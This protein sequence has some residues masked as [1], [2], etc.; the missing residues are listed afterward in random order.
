MPSKED[1]RSLSDPFRALDAKNNRDNALRHVSGRLM[2]YLGARMPEET[3]RRIML[4]RH[5]K[6]SYS[7]F[8]EVTDKFILSHVNSVYLMR[9]KIVEGARDLVVYVDNST[10]AAELNAQRE[11][12]RLKYRE[13]FKLVIDAFEIRI[14]KGEYL[15]KHPYVDGLGKPTEEATSLPELTDEEQQRIEAVVG[16]VEDERLRDS[17][18]A[19]MTASKRRE[20]LSK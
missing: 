19:A 11:L 3:R 10:I 1:T 13:N 20:K 6:K 16:E 15:K 7:Q 18:R 17:F 9:S 8:G 2:N 4:D 5:I 14:S 12:I